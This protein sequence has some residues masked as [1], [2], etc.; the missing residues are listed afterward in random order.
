VA[1]RLAIITTTVI[2]LVLAAGPALA[3]AEETSHSEAEAFGLWDGLI[4]AAIAGVIVGLAVF[5]D[6]YSGVDADEGHHDAH[7]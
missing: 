1:R 4:Y 5:L 2:G 6:A 7:H 3:A